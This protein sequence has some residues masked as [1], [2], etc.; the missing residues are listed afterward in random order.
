[1]SVPQNVHVNPA[2]L[3]TYLAARVPASAPEQPPVAE[4]FLEET[5][6]PLTP[7]RTAVGFPVDP[8]VSPAPEGGP[9]SRVAIRQR[10][11]MILA[12]GALHA[13]LVAAALDYPASEPP[14]AE[15][16][17]AH[18]MRA[19]QWIEATT[20]ELARVWGGSGVGGADVDSPGRPDRLSDE[21]RYE[22]ARLLVE[23]LR[24]HPDGP[25]RIEP[26][27][28]AAYLALPETSRRS[29]DPDSG[30]RLAEARTLARVLVAALHCDFQREV[31]TVLGE[32]WTAIAETAERQADQLDQALALTPDA[33]RIAWQRL[34]D[35]DGVLYAAALARVHRDS[36]RMIQSYQECLNT[37]DAAGADRLARAYQDRRLGYAG[38][39]HYFQVA[40]EPINRWVRA[41]LA[42]VE[43]PA[44]REAPKSMPGG[45]A[46]G[47]RRRTA[48]AAPGGGGSGP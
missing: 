4:T 7:P 24:E 28:L 27:R 38:I 30:Q 26:A 18:Q 22:I 6:Q 41:A 37:G 20:Q 19:S 8:G 21:R 46:S 32:A 35:A 34:L 23:V 45:A 36:V 31:T 47:A 48:A 15:A 33:R 2:Y 29:V 14:A 3:G 13:D 42:A 43:E 44:V 40:V 16:L 10:L 39:A 9:D 17:D 11:A 5:G 12:G 1:M 25:T